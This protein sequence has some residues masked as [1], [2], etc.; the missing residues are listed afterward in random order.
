MV[1][2]CSANERGKSQRKNLGSAGRREL[3]IGRSV[4]GGSVRV[5]GGRRQKI[6]TVFLQERFEGINVCTFT[7]LYIQQHLPST[8]CPISRR[9]LGSSQWRRGRRHDSRRDGGATGSGATSARAVATRRTV[10]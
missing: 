7:E 1:A 6:S 5:D 3:A 8:V 2:S 9:R 4:S 10:G